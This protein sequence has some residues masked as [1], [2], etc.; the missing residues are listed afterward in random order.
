MGLVLV[1]NLAMIVALVAVGLAAHS[2]GVLASAADYLGDAA[3]SGLALY[4]LRL[5]LRRSGGSRAPSIAGL[6]NASLLLLATIAVATEGLTRLIGGSP[7]VHGLPVLLVSLLAAAAM[8][9]CALILGDVAGADLGTRSVM[10]DTL[11]DA[12]AAAGVAA[13]GAIIW[14]AGGLYWLDASVALLIALVVGYHALGLIR[15]C[16]AELRAAPAAPPPP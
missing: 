7:E 13:S 5:Q 1:I 2:L 16:L 15:E 3:G 14:I 11:A 8:V 9:A 6:L 12:A 10:L 4:A